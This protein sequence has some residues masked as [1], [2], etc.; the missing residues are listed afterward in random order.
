M[1][2]ELRCNKLATGKLEFEK[3]LN[4]LVGPEDG[5]NS[6]GKSSVLMLIDFALAGEDFINLCSDVIDN[7]GVITI[8]MDFIF[9]GVRHCFSRST[10][11]PKVVVF[12]SEDEKP[13]KSVDEYRSFLKEGYIFPEEGASFRGAV[14]PFFR[15]WGKENDNPNKPL[16]SFAGEPYQKIKPNL[17][18]LFSFYGALKVLEKEKAATSKKKSILKGAFDEGYIKSLTKREKEKSVKRIEEVEF[19]IEKIKESIEIHS[20]NANQI[21]SEENFKIKS[22]KDDLVSSLFQVKSRQKRIEDNLTYGSTINKKYFEKLE[23]YF[24][25]VNSERLAKIEQFHS[26]V[27]K[28]LKAELRDEKLILDEQAKSIE[29]EISATEKKLLESAGMVEK[30]S[31]LVDKMLDL[32][33]EERSLRDQIRFRDIKSSIDIK[34]GVISEQITEKITQSLAEIES[35]LNSTMS[36]YISKFY[37][38]DPVVPQIKLSETR[39]EFKHNEDS[40]TGKAYAN[41]IALD[42]SFLEETYLPI[43]IHD[44]IVFSNIEDHAIEE[45]FEEYSLSNKQV[46]IAIDKLGRFKKE[47]QKLVNDKEFLVLDSK[48]LAFG[49]SWKKRT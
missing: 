38:G 26:G 32:S 25:E 19:E 36:K 22:E 40:G 42:M 44:L 13:E 24:P 5:A 1:L 30:P 34:V 3:G 39:Y 33:F 23:G 37:E 10:N 46:F 11:D 47:T 12:L 18:K 2:K 8:E 14:N 16:N 48:K 49:K 31:G 9:D 35:K 15:V 45:I 21:I 4:A 27:S 7:V 17:L 41:M 28:I 20:I 29:L 43:L 6:I